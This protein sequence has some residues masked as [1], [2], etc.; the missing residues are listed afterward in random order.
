VLFNANFAKLWHFADEE[1]LSQPHFTKIAN[2]AESR[3]G[4]DGIW[5]IVST[6][7]ASAEPERCNDWGKAV[8]ADGRVI[9]LSMSRLPNGATIATFSDMT[10]LERFREEQAKKPH[11]AA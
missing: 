4:H 10:D 8:R 1:L 7:I 2:L 6:G 3:L 11:A 9:S 5:S